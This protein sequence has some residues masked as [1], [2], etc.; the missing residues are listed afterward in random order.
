MSLSWDQS[1]SIFTQSTHAT[2]IRADYI[3]ANGC[4]R[5][6]SESC[7][8]LFVVTETASLWWSAEGHRVQHVTRTAMQ[9]AGGPLEVRRHRT[10]WTCVKLSH[11]PISGWCLPSTGTLTVRRSSL[12]LCDSERRSRINKGWTCGEQR[13]KVSGVGS[14]HRGQSHTWGSAA[15]ISQVCYHLRVRF[16]SIKK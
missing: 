5:A 16:L 2:F 14:I 3:R 10:R 13:Q 8:S 7:E 1:Y 9:W 4:G 15:I 12:F 6:F 11:L